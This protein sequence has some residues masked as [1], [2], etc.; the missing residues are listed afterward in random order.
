MKESNLKPIRLIQLLVVVA[1]ASL[2]SSSANAATEKS[3]ECEN[4]GVYGTKFMGVT[5][6]KIKGKLVA[7]DEFGTYDLKNFKTT[8]EILY[9][10]DEG[11]PQYGDLW[12]EGLLKG[13][14]LRSD[15]H[16]QPRR[17]RDHMRFQL[18]F[19]SDGWYYFIFPEFQE[20]EEDERVRA[21]AMFTGIRDHFGTTVHLSCK[22]K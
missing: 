21:V 17:Y 5:E 1:V 16:Y 20:I 8:Y 13:R 12:A 4:I 18:N 2:L 6:F 9:W 15:S 10:G 3:I 22:V 11:G 19:D 14:K 7:V